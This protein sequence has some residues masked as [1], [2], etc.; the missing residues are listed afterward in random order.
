MVYAAQEG[1]P[2]LGAA[3]H[4][5][6][7]EVP[8]SNAQLAAHYLA[9]SP[10][11]VHAIRPRRVPSQ[12]RLFIAEG[13][14]LFR[15]ALRMV[16]EADGGFVVVG[17]ASDGRDALHAIEQSGPEIALVDLGLPLLNGLE[18]ARRLKRAGISTR[19]IVLA[20]R[21]QESLLLR[22]L[23]TGA[24]GY[25]LKEADFQELTVALRRV[26]AG[27]SY[28]TPSLEGQPLERY[29]RRWRGG[30]VCGS[31]DLLTS[32]EREL[33]QLVG[34]GY[35]NREI[36]NQL[37]L[38]VKTVEAHQANICT[39]LNMRGRAALVRFAIHA[40]MIGIDG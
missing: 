22:T 32:R 21:A 28:L 16:L 38:S 10:S 37:C 15:Q 35:T 17:E 30:D 8:L 33:L 31:P 34:E 23:D 25:L 13:H 5:D 20:S 11:V 12:I 27:Y 40:G 26:H 29:V 1:A 6:R 7:K 14:T 36:A 3:P 18:V 24:A 19:V 2:Q 39:K 9:T 4:D